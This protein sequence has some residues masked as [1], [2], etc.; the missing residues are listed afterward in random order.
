[1]LKAGDPDLVTDE[2]QAGLERAENKRRE[3][4]DAPRAERE[5]ARV[6]ALMLRAANLYRQQIDLALDGDPASAAKEPA[7]SSR[8]MLGESCSLPE[9]S[10]SPV[11]PSGVPK[12]EKS[13][14]P[15]RGN[16]AFKACTFS[17]Q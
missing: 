4:L 1:V 8:E 9:R 15:Q 7:Q 16:P 17:S 13:A 10:A 3:L 5:N 6:L 11:A 12:L 14:G 2:L